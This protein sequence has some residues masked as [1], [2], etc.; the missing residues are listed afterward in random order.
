[1]PGS[2]DPIPE[3]QVGAVAYLFGITNSGT[4]IAMTGIVSFELDSDDLTSTWT[5]TKNKDTTG[6]TQ[7]IT[8]REFLYDRDIKFKPSGSSRAA[9]AQVAGEVL[10]L[11]NLIVSGY[12]VPAFNNTWRIKPGTKI[13]LK[14]DAEAEISIP[15]EFY[16]NPNQNV[17]L[18]SAPIVG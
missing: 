4:P 3:T 11:L 13:G 18:T 17:A 15:A 16:I 1:M 9:A 12:K 5:E 14:M 7:N 8:Q 2:Y 10:S 6:N